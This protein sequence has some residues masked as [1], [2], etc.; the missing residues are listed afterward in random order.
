MEAGDYITAANS[1]VA[2]GAVAVAWWQVRVSRLSAM[3]QME[4]LREQTARARDERDRADCPRFIL[5]ESDAHGGGDAAAEVVAVIQQTAGSDLDEAKVT[6]HLNHRPAPIIG[7]ADD[8]TLL[9]P[10]TGPTAMRRLRLPAPDGHRGILEIRADLVCREA[11]GGRTWAC[12]VF[13]YPSIEWEQILDEAAPEP[14]PPPPVPPPRPVP[15]A[16]PAPASPAAAPRRPAV[17]TTPGRREEPPMMH[18]RA[19]LPLVADRAGRLPAPEVL[20]PTLVHPEDVGL[21][22]VTPV[23]TSTA[24]RR[25]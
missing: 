14:P 17:A 7:G 4:Q 20:L 24:G 3:A 5:V 25:T 8:G 21:L 13:G 15:A 18:W 22:A 10:H 12:R 1:A 2:G 23:L 9:W 16:A 11:G 19:A 6:V